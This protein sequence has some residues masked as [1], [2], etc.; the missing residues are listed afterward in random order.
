M[1]NAEFIELHAECVIAMRG[2]F[3][4]AEITTAMLA[5]CTAQPLPFT[6][7][8]KSAFPRSHRDYRPNEICEC[9]TASPRCGPTRIRIF[10]LNSLEKAIRLGIIPSCATVSLHLSCVPTT[11][12]AHDQ[13]GTVRKPSRSCLA[14][15]LILC[16]FGQFFIS[17]VG[18]H[19]AGWISSTREK[20]MTVSDLPY[21]QW[22]K[23]LL[24]AVMELKPDSLTEN[25]KIAE[26]AIAQR[27][28][29]C[30]RERNSK[31]EE[32]WVALRDAASTLKVLKNVLSQSDR[33]YE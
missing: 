29:A 23:P 32:E 25:I 27:L 2:Y 13:G 33:D 8:M 19:S 18:W 28:R 31:S 3:I 5:K 4:E 22:Q 1:N 10:K 17:I 24:Q 26:T 16:L 12:G 30:E 14:A 9:K 21:P 15:A 20:S 7:R 6:D 11:Q